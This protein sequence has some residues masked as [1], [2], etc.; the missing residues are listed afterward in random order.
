MALTFCPPFKLLVTPN[1]VYTEHENGVSGHVAREEALSPETQVR[2]SD[3][4]IARAGAGQACAQ[5][6]RPP[7]S[8]DYTAGYP[9][10]QP[11]FK[12]SVVDSGAACCRVLF[13]RRA[14]D[15][16]S[17]DDALHAHDDRSRH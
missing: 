15:F 9:A 1:T 3:L 17:P 4:Q 12:I 16:A 10:L 11:M 6:A 2:A 8:N 5:I 7:A 13:S 14:P